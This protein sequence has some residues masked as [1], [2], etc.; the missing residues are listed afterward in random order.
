MVS[1]WANFI[2]LLYRVGYNSA[3]GLLWSSSAEPAVT[4]VTER[5]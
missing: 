2:I 1:E 4:E 3:L 5:S